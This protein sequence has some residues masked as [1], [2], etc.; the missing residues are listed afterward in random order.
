L[1]SNNCWYVHSSWYVLA[2]ASFFIMWTT[3]FGPVSLMMMMM[4]S[5][6]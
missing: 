1:K 3:M 5:C 2:H 4:Y 6:R